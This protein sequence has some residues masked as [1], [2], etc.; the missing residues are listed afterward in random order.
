MADLTNLPRHR[1]VTPSSSTSTSMAASPSTSSNSNYEVFI[2]HRGPDVKNTLASHLY[3]RLCDRGFRVF[4]DRE[5]M[6][7]GDRLDSQILGAIATSSVHIAIFSPRYAESRWCLDELVKMQESNATIV[8]VFYNV[9][10]SDLRIRMDEARHGLMDQIMEFLWCR[11]GYILRFLGFSGANN[12]VYD[13]AFRNHVKKMRCS[14]ETIAGWK[15]ALSDVSTLSGLEL[16]EY[17]RDEGELANVVVQVVEENVRKPQ[18]YVAKYPTGL[19]EKLQDF[20]KTGSSDT[21]GRPRLWGLWVLANKLHQGLTSQDL[22]VSNIAEGISVLSRR[23]AGFKA[24]VI[25]DDIDDAERLKAL[26]SPLKEALS[27]DSLIILTSRNRDFLS[28]NEVSSIYKL[29]G[30]DREKSQ[31]LFCMHAFQEPQPGAG[32]EEVVTK[33]LDTCDGLPLS[34]EVL[35]GQL[36]QKDLEYW[37]AELLKISDLVLPSDIQN[38]LKISYDCLDRQEKEIFLD[39]ACFFIEEDKDLVIKICDGSG[40]KGRLNL[41]NLEYKCILEIDSK[42]RI[43]MH[44][45]LRDLGR[46]FAEKELP[47]CHRRLWRPTDNLF[48]NAFIQPTV[49]GINMVQGTSGLL[50]RNPLEHFS[51][52]MSKLH[53]LR[54]EGDCLESLSQFLRYSDELVWLCWKKCPYT[55]LPSW[56]RIR[57][58]RAIQVFSGQLKTL[59]QCEIAAPLALEAPLKLE[60]SGCADFQMPTDSVVDLRNVQHISLNSCLSFEMLPACLGNLTQLTHFDLQGTRIKKVSFP[61]GFCPTLQHLNVSFCS[62][63]VE[64]GALPTTLISLDLQG[65][66]ALEKINGLP[67]LKNLR[68]LDISGCNEIEELLG[69]ESLTSLEELKG[70]FECKKLKESVRKLAE[71]TM[72]NNRKNKK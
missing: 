13:K 4:L 36:Y 67:G 55:S 1:R 51:V 27:S 23:L 18:L 29:S 38:S 6:Q 16:D 8:P 17:N 44:N 60:L 64:L 47:N 52:D 57:N 66:T 59:W 19:D 37:E 35:G 25:L 63:L 40:W 28:S 53:L 41:Q 42:N 72:D 48:H 21:A 54:A 31:S 69:L 11:L 24:L 39:I 45:H 49:R 43:R 32:F 10:P 7:V 20:E 33:F 46:D 58:L 62:Q 34:L 9:K 5:E 50:F 26:F 12:G 14:Q 71:E 30:L 61:K 15:Q 2:N 68:L 3:Y 56:I 22:R 70:I 65:S